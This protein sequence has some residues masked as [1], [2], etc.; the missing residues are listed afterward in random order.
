MKKLLLIALLALSCT[1]CATIIGGTKKKVVFDGDVKAPV[2]MVVDGRPYRNV[3]LPYKV[4]VKRGFS[5]SE[6][7]ITVDGYEPVTF[8]VGKDFNPWA[9]LNLADPVGWIIDLATGAVTR[10]AMTHYWVDFSPQK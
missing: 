4:N 1:S 6:V 2:T 8:W 7:R 5:A 10:P 3:V 9:L